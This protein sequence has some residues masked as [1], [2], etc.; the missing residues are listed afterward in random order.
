[1]AKKLLFVLLLIVTL[2][3]FCKES[4]KEVKQEVFDINALPKDWVKLTE[5][6][7][8][9]IV[10]NSCDSGNLLLNIS[11]KGNNFEILLH[12]QQ[13]DASFEILKANQQKDTVF[14]TTKSLDS[15]KKQVFKFFWTNKQKGLGRWT[16]KYPNG[17]V[18]DFTF[19][20]NENQNNF[21]IIDQP[22]KECWGEEC[23][24][25]EKNK[26]QTDKPIAVI[27]K[28]FDDYVSN[29]ESTDSDKSKDLMSKSIKAIG[30]IT[31]AED[32]EILINVWMYY[33]P[34]DFPSRDLVY[35]VL[36]K[37]KIE[38][39]KAVK[40]RIKNKKEWESIDSAP[41]SELN[42]LIKMLEK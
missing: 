22:C 7:E 9:F 1:M 30:V 26:E 5:K 24:E 4:K 14:I 2:V 6:N 42:Y 3:S 8:K 37:N 27:K 20:T 41:F 19:V 16:T 23:D 40:N 10:F 13:E 15:N 36:E 17:L 28:T 39:S 31:S 34:T 21:E 32:F 18:S 12:G 38:S 29:E 11:K 25:I 33:D 35:S